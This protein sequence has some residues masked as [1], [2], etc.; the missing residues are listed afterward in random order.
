MKLLHLLE[1]L[2]ELHD[3]ASGDGGVHVVERLDLASNL[4]EPFLQLLVLLHTRERLGSRE[5]LGCRAGQ[6]ARDRPSNT[7]SAHGPL[8]FPV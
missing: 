4:L 7:V 3:L 6:T 1:G 5:E 2:D 8:S